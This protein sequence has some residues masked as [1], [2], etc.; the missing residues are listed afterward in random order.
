MTTEPDELPPLSGPAPELADELELALALA[1][2]G[3]P[4]ELEELL[5]EQA[6]TA[7][8]PTTAS[9]AIPLLA[10]ILMVIGVSSVGG[11]FS[12]G[13]LTSAGRR[14]QPSQN[15]KASGGLTRQEAPS[16]FRQQAL[17]ALAVTG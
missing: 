3:V 4:E 17:F 9:A 14:N 1:G 10:E 12:S 2:A 6:L 11:L 15:G 8:T 5:L 13:L 16:A 7:A